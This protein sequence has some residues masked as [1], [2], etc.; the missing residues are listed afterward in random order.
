MRGPQSD[1]SSYEGLTVKRASAPQ[2]FRHD[3]TVATMPERR[4]S[5]HSP[6]SNKCFVVPE[7]DEGPDADWRE[8]RERLAR[9]DLIRGRML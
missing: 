8:L 9:G 7:V 3:R 2:T 1:G 5:P 6:R 4:T